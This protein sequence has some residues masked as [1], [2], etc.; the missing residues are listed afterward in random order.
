MPQDRLQKYLH[1]AIVGWLIGW[2][3]LT[4]LVDWTEVE[5]K[6]RTIVIFGWFVHGALIGIA[7]TAEV[8]DN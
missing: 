4:F 8:E 6:L 2:V 5:P 7:Y 3:L 1:G